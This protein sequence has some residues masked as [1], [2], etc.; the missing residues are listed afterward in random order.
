MADSR[1]D[2]EIGD[3]YDEE[4]DMVPLS[5]WERVRE[6]F[7]RFC[8]GTLVED[9]GR[10]ECRSGAATFAVTRDGVVDTGMPLHEFGREGVEALG[11][12][13]GNGAIVIRGTDG[14]RYVFRQ[15]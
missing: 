2:P 7:E 9:D 15:P 14:L 10:I 6:A 11:F 12:D 3:E 8:D 5:D 13:H 4:Y 1:D